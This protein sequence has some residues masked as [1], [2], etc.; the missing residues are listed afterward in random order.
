[1]RAIGMKDQRRWSILE[2][3]WLGIISELVAEL[4]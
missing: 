4:R 2:A 1:M 3:M